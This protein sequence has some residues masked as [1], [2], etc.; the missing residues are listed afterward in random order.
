MSKLFTLIWTGPRNPTSTSLQITTTGNRFT[1]VPQDVNGL[2][3]G[4]LTWIR[5]HEPS[6]GLGWVWV[7]KGKTWTQPRPMKIPKSGSGPNRE[8]YLKIIIAKKILKNI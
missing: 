1:V 7:R 6:P 4:W 5:T 8:F 3:L 2:S